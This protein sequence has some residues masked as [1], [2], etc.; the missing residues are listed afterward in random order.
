MLK[1]RSAQGPGPVSLSSRIWGGGCVSLNGDART[2]TGLAKT[3]DWVDSIRSPLNAG[4][5]H[6]HLDGSRGYAERKPE[7]TAAT[8]GGRPVSDTKERILNRRRNEG[9]EEDWRIRYSSFRIPPHC[10]S[11]GLWKM[12]PGDSRRTGSCRGCIHANQRNIPSTYTSDSCHTKIAPVSERA[13]IPLS[14][15]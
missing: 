5:E 10:I 13:S 3:P 12:R 8:S 2:R 9:V 4:L 7:S 6:C 11:Q 1:Y 14:M 15:P